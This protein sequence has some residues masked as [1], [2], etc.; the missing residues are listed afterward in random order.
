M[1]DK[2]DEF[3]NNLKTTICSFAGL[4]LPKNIPNWIEELG[5]SANDRITNAVRVGSVGHKT[6]IIIN[7]NNGVCLKVSA[8]MSSADYFGNWYSHQRIVREFGSDLFQ[9]LTKDCTEWANSWIDSDN[10]S[11]FVGVSISFGKRTGDTAREFTDIFTAND[12]VKIV[13]GVGGGIETANCLYSSSMLPNSIDDLFQTLKPID[14]NT[15]VQLSKNFKIIYRPINPLTERSNRGKCTYTQF[16]PCKSYQPRKTVETLNDLK[17][18]GKFYEVT[19]NGLNHNRVLQSLEDEYNI[20]IP[21][22]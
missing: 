3:E 5:I 7:F 8:K 14:T 21:R 11:L 22:K 12:I 6:D 2:T 9:K 10:A 15:V 16:K 13:A 17:K 1:S 19:D 18:L 4:A 20:F